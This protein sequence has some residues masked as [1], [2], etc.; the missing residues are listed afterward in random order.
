[1]KR[2]TPYYGSP[3]ALMIILIASVL[4]IAIIGWIVVRIHFHEDSLYVKQAAVTTNIYRIL[5]LDEVL[6]LSVHLVAA[7]GDLSYEEQ[8]NKYER[9]LR[10]LID[11]T[12]GMFPESEAK[13][14]GRETDAAN[15]RLVE[16]E[17]RA[18]AL[19][20]RGRRTDAS[21]LLT[22][23]EYL[24]QKE[25][26]ARNM[27]KTLDAVTALNARMVRKE[28]SYQLVLFIVSLTG[29]FIL[30]LAW[31]FTIRKLHKWSTERQQQEELV[32][33]SQRQ[34]Q[35]VLD[36]LDA[37]VY[38]SD[39]KTYELLMLNK[40]GR[41]VWGDIVGKTCW[42]TLQS[43]QTGPCL[44]CTNAQLLLPGGEPAAPVVWEFQNTVN[45]RWYECRDQAIRWPDGRLV[46]M[47]IATDISGR[48]QF[49]E[50][51]NSLIADLQKALKEIKT[52]QKILPICSSCKKIRD[53]TGAWKQLEAYI[54]EHT[55]TEFSHGLCNDC[56]Q[57][58]YPGYYKK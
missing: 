55:E 16:M 17:R 50:E 52:L 6:T 26:Y 1:M 44:F 5:H 12:I 15:S 47:E 29:L 27:E 43:G 34:L 58:L 30:F 24:R 49:E 33:E 23:P 53:D 38:V 31:I 39:M 13:Q 36:G 48:K 10:T 19:V 46:R 3:K 9:E 4:V 18:F 11:E 20:H 14:Y 41:Q 21:A 54:S 35:V 57:K 40:Y 2:D 42:Q 51:R 25:I 28:H 56:A 45:R 32:A 37:L 22:G 8:Y 7:T